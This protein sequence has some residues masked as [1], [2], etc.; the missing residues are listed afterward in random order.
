MCRLAAYVGPAISLERFLL[1]PAHGLMQQSWRPREMTGGTINADGYGFGWFDDQGRNARYTHPLPIWNDTNLPALARALS[2]PT[3]VANVRG[4]TAPS[5]AHPANTQPFADEEFLFL[6]NGAVAEF[7][8]GLRAHLHSV[9]RD[10]IAADI[11]G[12]TDSEYLF[13]LLRQLLSEDPEL[14]PE[15]ALLRLFKALEDWTDGPAGLNV[16][17]A[18]GERLYAVR[19]ALLGECPSLY[20]TTDDDDYPDGLLVASEPLTD[21]RYWQPVPEHHLL[22]LDPTEPP[23]LVPL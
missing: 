9:L 5:T 1:R 14:P 23:E 17:L 2:A 8:H 13:A 16:I 4:A 12:N 18:D 7:H 6:H 3:W 19:H 22:I 11:G 15:E 20:F 21:S 10:E